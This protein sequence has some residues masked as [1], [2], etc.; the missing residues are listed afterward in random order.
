MRPR[1]LGLQLVELIE[2]GKKYD[3]V[4]GGVVLLRYATGVGSEASKT[5]ASTRLTLFLLHACK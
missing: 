1:M 3:L 2:K 5:Q 4:G